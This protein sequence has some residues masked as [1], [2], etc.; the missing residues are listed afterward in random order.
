MY[1][2]QIAGHR[3]CFL[4]GQRERSTEWYN[5]LQAQQ[6]AGAIDYLKLIDV[7]TREASKQ[8]RQQL[9]NIIAA[10]A[11]I[12]ADQNLDTEDPYFNCIWWRINHR[13]GTPVTDSKLSCNWGKDCPVSINWLEYQEWQRNTDHKLAL[14]ASE[15]HWWQLTDIM[16]AR[17]TTYS[18]SKLGYR[19]SKPQLH[20]VENQ[21]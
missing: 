17:V 19:R 14:S 10:R 6:T 12:I 7:N 20:L 21:P 11:A 3:A 13:R 4:I 9:T 18:W 5:R 1:R 2:H 15:Q 16:A 8:Q